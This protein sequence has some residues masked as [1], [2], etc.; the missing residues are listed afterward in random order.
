MMAKSGARGT[1]QQIRQL[2]GMR[3]LMSDPTGRIIDY[4]IKTN[5]REGLTVLE[6]FISTHGARKGLADTALRT[7]DSGYLTRRLV[8]VAQDI[9]IQEIDCGTPRGLEMESF[10]VNAQP[11]SIVKEL[12][13]KDLKIAK[14]KPPEI[15][16][17]KVYPFQKSA[18]VCPTIVLKGKKKVISVKKIYPIRNELG[19]VVDVRLDTRKT[20]IDFNVVDLVNLSNHVQGL[21]GEKLI[22][23][24]AAGDI[25]SAVTGEVFA[26]EGE[27][28]AEEDFEN[29]R[30]TTLSAPIRVRSVM[31]CQTRHGVCA[32]CYGRNFAT[33]KLAEIGDTVGIIAAQS[34]G[35]P[36]TQLT[37]RTFHTGGV[38]GE[39]ISDITQGLP[40]VEELFEARRPKNMAIM[41]E[42][43]GKV[44]IANTETGRELIITQKSA[45]EGARKERIK[46]P[47]DSMVVVKNGTKIIMGQGLT[48]GYL[49]PHDVLRV[50]GLTKTQEY[51]VNEVISVYKNQGVDTN[52]KHV[53]VIVR[54]MLRRI[55]IE[56]PGDSDFLPHS[57][58]DRFEFDR[59]N[60]EMRARGKRPATGR[61]IL[62]GITKCSLSTDSFL[63]AASFQETT[64]VLTDA[65]VRGK[66]DPLMGLKSRLSMWFRKWKNRH[67]PKLPPNS[68]TTIFRSRISKGFC[69]MP[70]MMM[71]L[72]EK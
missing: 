2:A 3:G 51:L 20:H 45:V 14:K 46:V 47:P 43:D 27:M 55:R 48:D 62:L 58:V 63:S 6:Y 9:I 33:G 54:E 31:E 1:V 40:R 38:S 42:V 53:E 13:I 67:W 18:A 59:V 4:P 41:S 70:A 64:R 12:L 72:I 69:P 60:R 49:N 44:E 21:L 37:M 26:A 11:F 7:A 34:I 16:A 52:E 22:G 65:A 23:R 28:I 19:D 29:M 24:I 39:D 15:R 36:G 68:W 17:V 30:K 66:I 10:Y 57:L 25:F 8:D 5:F 35:E 32:K 56:A 71:L 50:L 61:S